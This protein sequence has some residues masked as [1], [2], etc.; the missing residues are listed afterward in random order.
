MD[1][2]ELQDIIPALNPSWS[3]TDVTDGYYNETRGR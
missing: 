3:E 2:P 1:V